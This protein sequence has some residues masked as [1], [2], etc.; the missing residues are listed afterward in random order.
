VRHRRAA[1]SCGD[2]FS[3]NMP[4]SLDRRNFGFAGGQGEDVISS[5]TR[6]VT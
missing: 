6:D 2:A 1:S 4:A 3:I 5:F